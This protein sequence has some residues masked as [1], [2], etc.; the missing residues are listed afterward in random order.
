MGNDNAPDYAN[1]TSISRRGAGYYNT[2]CGPILF[3][4]FFSAQNCSKLL[5]LAQ[6]CVFWYKNKGQLVSKGHFGV[7]K[8][9]K[10]PTNFKEEV[11]S[12]QQRHFIILN[13]P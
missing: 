13:S 6:T 9:T 4:I 1:L 12:K 8:S 11:E 2:Q 5:K 7:F 10:K 3:L